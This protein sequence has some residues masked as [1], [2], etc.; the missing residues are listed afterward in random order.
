MSLLITNIGELVT[1]APGTD[2]AASLAGPGSFALTVGD[3]RRSVAVAGE[4]TAEVTFLGAHVVPPESDA[5]PA[6]YQ[7]LVCGPMLA[8]CAP[9]ARWIDVFC[10]R[11]AFGADEARAVL[12]AGHA[13][14]RRRVRYPSPLPGRAPAA[15]RRG[16]GGHR[17]R[18]SG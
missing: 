17:H 4:I 7:D 2:E 5:D 1:N 8:A 14:A 11:G 6:G 16:E 18:K 12:A 9:R 13:A 3:E 10:E 15:G